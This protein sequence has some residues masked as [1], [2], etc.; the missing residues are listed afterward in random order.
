MASTGTTEDEFNPGRSRELARDWGSRWND[1]AS[2]EVSGV[3]GV[4]GSDTELDEEDGGSDLA[5]EKDEGVEGDG[6]MG[7]TGRK[8][9]TSFVERKGRNGFPLASG[10]SPVSSVGGVELGRQGVDG[11]ISDVF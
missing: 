2:E 9:R 11:R 7:V 5:V 3:S 10:G 4:S 1:V 8:L 6:E